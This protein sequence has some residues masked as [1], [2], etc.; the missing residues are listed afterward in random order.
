[1]T[2][3]F[4]LIKLYCT[5][6]H[7]YN[8]TLAAEAQRLS[9]NFRPKFTVEE[10]ITTYLFGIAAGKFSVRATYDFIKEYWADWFPAMPRYQNYNRRINLLAESFQT[11]YGLLITDSGT[12]IGN[13]THLLD[14]MPVIVANSK[15]S[16]TAKVASELC[17]KGY[18]ASKGMYYYGVKLHV[19]GQKQYQALPSARMVLVTSASENDITVAKEWLSKVKGFELYADK[20]YASELWAIELAERGVTLFTPIKLKKGQEYLDSWDKLFSSAV[21]RARQAIESFFSW[22]QAKTHIQSASCVRSAS[23]LI[24]FIFARLASL[25]FFNS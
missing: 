18:C 17:D 8:T 9:N 6:C 13:L 12:E 25:A 20:A 2:K 11:L 14:S 5:V 23:G 24:A 15:R 3:D 22:I 19:L 7:H 1:M 10:C 21:S 4:Q 16:S